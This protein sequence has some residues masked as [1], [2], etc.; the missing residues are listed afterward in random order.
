MKI[1]EWKISELLE[2]NDYGIKLSGNP[3]I[4]DSQYGKAV[5][6]NGKDDG[7]F[8]DI[9]PIMNMDEFTVEAIFYP[10][11]DGQFEQRFLHIGMDKEDR[12][13]LETRTTNNNQWYLDAFIAIGN[14]INPLF[15]KEKLHST[16]EWHHIAFVIDGNNLTSY[17]DGIKEL[18]GKG[19]LAPMKSG[20]TSIGVRQ[21]K[22]SWFKGII[23]NI[24]IT[25]EAL[26]PERFSR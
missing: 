3:T 6:F 9:N 7:I 17:V 8:L 21:N 14:S 2:S 24:K 20:Q 23:Y 16:N 22:I 19:E 11:N 5:R 4:V 18:T 25:H 26:L 15:D 12:L 10:D 1:T 13:L